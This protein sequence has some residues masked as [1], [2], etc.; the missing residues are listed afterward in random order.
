LC[1][2][3]ACAFA[4]PGW[5]G[6]DSDFFENKIRPILVNNCYGCHTNSQLGGLRLDSRDSILKGGK[7]GPAIIAG[8]PEGSLLIQ[9]VR[10]RRTIG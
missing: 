6:T 3:L 5:S 10:Q 4:L 9:A 2:A 8:D 1:R 7:A